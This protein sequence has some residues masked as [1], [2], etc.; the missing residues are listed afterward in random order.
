VFHKTQHYGNVRWNQ[1][2]GG[3]VLL[4]PKRRSRGVY[5]SILHP[6]RILEVHQCIDAGGCASLLLPAQKPTTTL[7]QAR[8]ETR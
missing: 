2:P 3:L 4:R 1:S 6:A 7:N 8:V 5:W